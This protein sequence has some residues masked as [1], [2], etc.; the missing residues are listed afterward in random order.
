MREKW[1]RFVSL[2]LVGVLCCS[3]FAGCSSQVS[4]ANNQGPEEISQGKVT[5]ESISIAQGENH[6]TLSSDEIF[7]EDIV[8]H[9]DAVVI[10]YGWGTCNPSK[11]TRTDEHT[12][13]LSFEAEPASEDME[14][15]YADDMGHVIVSGEQLQTGK[16]VSADFSIKVPVLTSHSTVARDASQLTFDM[17]LEHAELSQTIGTEDITLSKAFEGMEV[18]NVERKSETELSLTLMGEMKTENEQLVPYLEGG[19]AIKPE[20]TTAVVAG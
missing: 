16:A 18:T 2:F 7:L 19:V 17:T 9:L 5:Q 13:E 11:V 20:A 6:L 10:D 3:I 8:N 12:L 4:E 1:M 14:A 15:D